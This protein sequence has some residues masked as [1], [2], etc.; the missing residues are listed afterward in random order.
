MPEIA[1]LLRKHQVRKAYVFGSA[2]SGR[3]RP[4]SDVDFFV[5]FEEGLSPKAYADHFWTLYLE[6]PIIVARQVDL[7]TD[8]NLRNPFFI[9]ELDETKIAI[10]DKESEEILV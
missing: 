9:E 6:L 10:Y 5:L 1:A 3:L 7:I 8:A 2:A 4:D